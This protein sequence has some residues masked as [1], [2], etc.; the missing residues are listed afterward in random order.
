MEEDISIRVWD[1]IPAPSR[2]AA[3]TVPPIGILIRRESW[4]QLTADQKHR[5]LQH[6]FTHWSQYLERGLVRFYAEYLWLL[7]R[8]GYRRHPMEMEARMAG[9]IDGLA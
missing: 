8:H 2:F 7:I 5:L 9:R 6:E 3:I 4:R 1:R